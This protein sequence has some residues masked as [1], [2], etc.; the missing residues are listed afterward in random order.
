M[1]FVSFSY[2]FWF[3]GRLWN[4]QSKHL[5]M[6]GTLNAHTQTRRQNNTRTSCTLTSKQNRKLKKKK[7]SG[8]QQWLC[9]RS[10]YTIFH[11]YCGEKTLNYWSAPLLP[12]LSSSLSCSLQFNLLFPCLLIAFISLSLFYKSASKTRLL[13]WFPV[14]NKTINMQT[15]L[16]NYVH[17]HRV[18]PRR[19]T[20]THI[21]RRWTQY[22]KHLCNLMQSRAVALQ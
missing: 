15:L 7:N 22:Q 19:H 8:A 10:A 14:V 3:S 21:Q 5:W 9:T 2:T 16:R 12:F 4:K 20:Y 1:R 11:H 18:L 6:A 17:K 13:K